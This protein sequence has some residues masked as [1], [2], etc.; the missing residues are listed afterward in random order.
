MGAE[1][2]D[3]RLAGGAEVKPGKLRFDK[4]QKRATAAM[5]APA[6]PSLPVVAPKKSKAQPRSRRKPNLKTK[7]TGHRAFRL[8]LARSNKSVCRDGGDVGL[9]NPA[10]LNSRSV[11]ERCRIGMPN[12]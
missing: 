3:A 11:Y 5:M 4:K 9:I 1:D 2:I 7:E 6:S 12:E 10:Q 8:A